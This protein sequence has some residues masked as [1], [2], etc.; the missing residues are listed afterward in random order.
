V[1]VDLGSVL[2]G[3]LTG[4]VTGVI[5]L[6][7]VVYTQRRAT[8]RED[9][10]WD[11]EREREQDLWARED[12]A[13]TFNVRRDAYLDFYKELR[14]TAETVFDASL[15]SGPPL[16]REWQ[17]QLWSSLLDLDVFASGR[18]RQAAR[19]AYY[20]CWWWGLGVIDVREQREGDGKV[21]RG[22]EGAHEGRGRDKDE[23]AYHAAHEVLLAAI[24]DELGVSRLDAHRSETDHQA[25][26]RLE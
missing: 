8:A 10:R 12:A 24:R 11:R 13:R 5:A 7:G 21:A 25:G 16:D 1:R 17:A 22:D 23:E 4:L 2:P 20:A 6:S 9:A 3:L 15:E 14:R 19:S 18:V 26:D